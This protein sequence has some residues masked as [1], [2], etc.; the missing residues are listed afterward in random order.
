MYLFGVKS[1]DFK[2]T[3]MRCF[4]TFDEAYAYAVEYCKQKRDAFS[5]NGIIPPCDYGWIVSDSCIWEVF[6]DKPPVRAGFLMDKLMK[7]LWPDEL[8]T[9]ANGEEE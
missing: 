4:N 7:E 9:S 5:A 6:P 2:S 8:H 1:P 3:R